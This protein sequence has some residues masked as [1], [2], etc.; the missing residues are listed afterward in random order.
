[1]TSE[2]MNLIPGISFGKVLI[3]RDESKEDKR[4]IFYYS[5]LPDDIAKK[6][7][8]F[9]LD[10]MCSTG[11]SASMCIAKLREHGVSPDK[12]TFINLVSVEE[13]LCRVI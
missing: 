4:P 10:P 13:G 11:G 3:Q 2:M 12:I 6:H 1:M 7:R 9:V 8:V 5:K